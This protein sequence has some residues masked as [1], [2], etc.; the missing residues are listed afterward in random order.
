MLF[1]ILL[2]LTIYANYKFKLYLIKTKDN[3]KTDAKNTSRIEH[4]QIKKLNEEFKERTRSY[5]LTQNADE[6]ESRPIKNMNN[7]RLKN[8]TKE[9]KN[10]LNKTSGEQIRSIIFNQK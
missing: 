3:E 1:I 6:K 7:E 9:N 8:N 5:N 10:R 2:L 4:H